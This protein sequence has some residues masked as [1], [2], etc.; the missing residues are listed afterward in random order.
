MY[1]KSV[2]FKLE[3]VLKCYSYNI[4]VI[5]YIKMIIN[6]LF[7]AIMSSQYNYLT[8]TGIQLCIQYDTSHNRKY[9]KCRFQ[10]KIRFGGLLRLYI[11]L[12]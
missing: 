2:R 7:I 8:A 9:S 1:L 4:I 5:S 6:I 11:K 3:I 12:F 10:K